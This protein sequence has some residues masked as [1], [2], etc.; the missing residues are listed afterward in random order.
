MATASNGLSADLLMR[1]EAACKEHA[2]EVQRLQSGHDS[3]GAP[4]DRKGYERVA[5]SIA[6]LQPL[7]DAHEE[8]NKWREE[9]DSLK[10][11]LDEEESGSEMADLAMGELEE[12]QTSLE[13]AQQRI[14]IALL[15]KD[16]N[17]ERNVILEVR[18]GVGGDEATLFAGELFRMYQK[19]SQAMGWRF[20]LLS[21]GKS[22][23]ADQGGG[24]SGM[25]DASASISGVDVYGKLKHESGVHRVQRV[26][27]TESSG[28]MHTSAAAVVVMPQAERADVKQS[29]S[30]SDLKID[31]MR[32]SGAGG[33]SVNTT[34]SAVRIT[35][36][37]NCRLDDEL[38]AA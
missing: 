14:L 4:L 27:A 6:D 33:Q 32:S 5:K 10:E 11:L 9:I 3:E 26:P 17:E 28:R 1:V 7:V 35:L 34:D 16:K 12:A 8:M 30:P 31:T 23:V 22:S 13:D 38:I 24:S 20:E 18:A 36:P 19:Y 21:L 29:L 37:W 2:N 25:K 15:P